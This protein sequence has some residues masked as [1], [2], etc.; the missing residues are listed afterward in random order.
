MNNVNVRLNSLLVIAY[1]LL[2]V[3]SIWVGWEFETT[4]NPTLPLVPI[5]LVGLGLGCA[6]MAGKHWEEL[7]QD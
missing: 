4:L 7:P 1:A 6:A 5:G 3:A 2:S